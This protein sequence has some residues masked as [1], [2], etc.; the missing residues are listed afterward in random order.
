LKNT[1][2]KQAEIGEEMNSK[3]VDGNEN[4]NMGNEEV[5]KKARTKVRTVYLYET[6]EGTD[7]ELKKTEKLVSSAR[8]TL[9][10]STCVS[11]SFCSSTVIYLS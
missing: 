6:G 4:R 1:R 8:T 10:S 11:N 5:G 2:N 3:K 7:T 9:C